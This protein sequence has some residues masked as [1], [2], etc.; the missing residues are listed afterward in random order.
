MHG[1]TGE[2]CL[3]ELLNVEVPIKLELD[4]LTTL[5]WQQLDAGGGADVVPFL[6]IADARKVRLWFMDGMV[7]TPTSPSKRGG[8]VDHEFEP[9][10]VPQLSFEVDRDTHRSV[11]SCL[12]SFG[13]RL[14]AARGLTGGS[15]RPAETMTGS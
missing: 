8:S 9:A 7:R 6:L 5:V 4:R 3:R 1:R 12:T 14:A 13:L 10:E 15:A 11:V 2:L